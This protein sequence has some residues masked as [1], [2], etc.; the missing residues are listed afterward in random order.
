MRRGAK[1]PTAAG[2]SQLPSRLGVSNAG[3]V[4]K[5]WAGSAERPEEAWMTWQRLWHK[6]PAVRTGD[7]L[8]VGERA[9]DT[10]RNS[11]GSWPFVF[12][13][14]GFMIA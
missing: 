1:G 14:F 2:Y 12:A 8:S 10:M 7:Q 9:A 13:F 5:S 3:C 6:H 4:S 11:M